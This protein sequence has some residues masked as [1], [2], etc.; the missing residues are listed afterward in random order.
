MFSKVPIATTEPDVEA[1]QQGLSAAARL[2]FEPITL[3]FKELRYFVPAPKGTLATTEGGQKGGKKKKNNAPQLELLKGLT[4]W[5]AP[6]VLTAL[7]GGSGVICAAQSA[8][9]ACISELLP[10]HD[11]VCKPVRALQSLPFSSWVQLSSNLKMG[12]YHPSTCHLDASRLAHA[13][14]AAAACAELLWHVCCSRPDAQL[15]HCWA[16]QSPFNHTTVADHHHQ[17]LSHR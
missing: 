10:M 8:S 2:P 16:H 6:G 11:V 5:A 13:H 15:P 9:I 3:I 12:T 7:M 1:G 17:A 14:A 4:G